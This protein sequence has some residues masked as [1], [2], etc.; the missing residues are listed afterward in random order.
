MENPNFE[1]SNLAED[2]HTLL[3]ETK[4]ELS[5]FEFDGLNEL[6][7]KISFHDLSKA[8]LSIVFAGQYSAGKSSIIKV[9]TNDESIE[10]G[11][12]ITTNKT[13]FYKWNGVEIIDSPGIH[14]EKRPDHD[15]I[16]YKAISAADLV[17]FV[18]TNE[19]FDDKIG[20]HFRKLTI[21]LDK[22]HEMMLVL[23]KM[24]REQQG[25]NKYTQQL[26]TEDIEK[27]IQPFSPEQLYISF[28]DAEAAWKSKD[29]QDDE[30]KVL[31]EKRSGINDFKRSLNQFISDKGFFTRLTTPLYELEQILQEA[32]VLEPA[33]DQDIEGML[34]LLTQKRR[35]LFETKNKIRHEVHATVQNV[36]ST[37]NEKGVFISEL[38]HENANQDEVNN[39]IKK[40]QIEIE[41]LT[42]E[43]ITDIEKSF[44]NI[45]EELRD[46]LQDILNSE[47]VKNLVNRLNRRF[48]STNVNDYSGIKNAGNYGAK[49]GDFLVA[50]SFSKK[51]GVEGLMKLA[52]FSGS[53]TH[54]AVLKMG[55][56]F[57]K[58]FK[59]WEA[60]KWSRAIGSAGK[61]L[62]VAGMVLNVALD[63]KQDAD[64]KKMEKD[65]KEARTTIRKG[66]RD[67]SFELEKYCQ[68]V[69]ENFIQNI[70]EQEIN[71]VDEQLTELRTLKD[72]NTDY[73]NTIIKIQNRTHSLIKEIH[74]RS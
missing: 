73:L 1:Y 53:N 61:M 67:V 32:V 57:G 26:L 14:T 31:R 16:T 64:E 15:E 25:N 36:V 6:I 4:K 29:E 10:I 8:T 5:T 58:K 51:E 47:F 60:V 62:S 42:D 55:H 33:G 28:T 37:I 70:I 30:I 46:D 24:L 45:L 34:H 69:T 43:L 27:V 40:A 44:E 38:I 17:I 19:L 21:D 74:V 54:K 59:P 9:L 12:D 3:I 41:R 72:T 49:L 13:S 65:L 2:V 39:E 11:S 68:E 20:K 7:Q 35:T 48:S 71:Q 23:N 50:N 56:L 18:V 22:G 52:Q 66:F 63:F